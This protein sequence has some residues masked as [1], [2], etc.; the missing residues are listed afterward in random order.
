MRPAHLAAAT[1]RLQRLRV[2]AITL[3]L[4]STPPGWQH[5]RGLLGGMWADVPS[6]PRVG[7]GRPVA[8][9]CAPGVDEHLR[10][11]ARLHAHVSELHE[12]RYKRPA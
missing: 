3:E 1:S 5:V 7:E 2:V 8:H 4:L 6:L 9:R 10:L 12:L 11:D